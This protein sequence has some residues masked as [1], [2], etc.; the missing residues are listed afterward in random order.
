MPMIDLTLEEGALTE[1]AKA[2]LIGELTATLIELEGA[3]DNDYVRAISWCFVDQRPAGSIHVGGAPGARPVYRVVLTVPEG[4]PGLQGPLGAANRERL[5][6]R[7]T[8]LVLNA[9]G[10]PATPVESGRVWVQI[11]EIRDGFWGA[12]GE[13]ARME[14]IAT[15]AGA[16]PAGG[17][18]EKGERARAAFEEAE[19]PTTLRSRS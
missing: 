10:T 12:F 16:P 6:K 8:E 7:I 9:E 15:Y 5:V 19:L 18:T 11:R 13:V 17:P 3:P 1:E 2:S 14:D 4:A